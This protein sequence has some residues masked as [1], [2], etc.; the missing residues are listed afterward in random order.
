MVNS[1]VVC[2]KIL[3]YRWVWTSSSPTNGFLSVFGFGVWCL[4]LYR[5][6]SL[7]CSC[8]IGTRTSSLT[9]NWHQPF[10]NIMDC[11]FLCP[12]II[13]M[14]LLV[15]LMFCCRW[16]PWSPTKRYEHWKKSFKN[17]YTD[18]IFVFFDL[19]IIIILVVQSSFESCQSN[20][21]DIDIDIDMCGI[22]GRPT[23]P[24]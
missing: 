4:V 6:V 23:P 8:L 21:V 2:Q 18:S 15:P 24:W 1:C 14:H 9:L 17:C 10:A 3:S 20:D 16:R 22:G 19:I 5:Y 11:L 12:H 13:I 7:C